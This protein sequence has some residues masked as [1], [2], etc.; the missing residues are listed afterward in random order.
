MKSYIIFKDEK[1]LKSAELASDVIWKKGLLLKGPG[2]C[3]GVA[4]NGYAFLI[5]Y[6]L[7]NNPKYFYRASKFM[8]FLTH[9]EFK[10]KANTPDRP[11]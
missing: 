4:G 10:A 6:R 3:H 2:I 11:F 5:L 7:T 1:Y 9:P 8:E